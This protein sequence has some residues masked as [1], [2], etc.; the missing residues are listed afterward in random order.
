MSQPAPDLA[1]ALRVLDGGELAVHG[2]LP[3]ASNLTLLCTARLAETSLRCVYKPVAGERPLS[4]F[5]DGS[6]AGRERAAYLL[7]EAGGWDLVPPTVL[8]EGPLGPGSC[9]LWVEADP[10]QQLVAVLPAGDDHPGWF[11]V[12]RAEAEQGPVLVAHRDQPALRTLA[13]YDAVVNNA[14]RKGSHLLGH[15]PGQVSGVDHGI[16]FAAGDKLRTLLWGWRGQPVTATDLALLERTSRA[17]EH[18]L[19]EQLAEHLTAVEL[20]ALADRVDRLRRAGHYPQPPQDRPAV[21]WPPL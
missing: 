17:L 14:D 6:L 7:S 1:T 8:R 3:E 18:G 16:C 11:P 20:A 12:L 9:Q 2:R 5:P 19:A 15:G 21:P 13:L 4:D 10:E